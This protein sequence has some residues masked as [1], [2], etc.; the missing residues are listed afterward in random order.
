MRRRNAPL[1]RSRE[2]L[3]YSRGRA[4]VLCALRARRE[5]CG[6]LI[7]N[8]RGARF[9]EVLVLSGDS[10]SGVGPSLEREIQPGIPAG[11]SRGCECPL[12][13]RS[14]LAP[15]GFCPQGHICGVARLGHRD[16][17]GAAP[18]RLASAPLWTETRLAGI[19]QRFLN[20]AL[21][22]INQRLKFLMC[23]LSQMYRFN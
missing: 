9:S 8:E 13:I 1:R 4:G 22:P 16:G 19:D 17:Y 7:A 10:G 6:W 23:S 20:G 21:D 3:I 2:P 15:S 5:E 14:A 11:R 12:D 18:G